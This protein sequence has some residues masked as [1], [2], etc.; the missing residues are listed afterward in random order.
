VIIK[1]IMSKDVEIVSPETLLHDVAKKM[2]VRDLGCIL[3]GKDDKLVGMITD[4]DIA[5]RCVALEH[6]P[7]E[8]TAEKIMSAEIL[9]CRETDEA[10]D[11]AKNMA[12]NKV[13]RLVVLDANKRMVGIVSLGDLAIAS[14]DHNICGTA[15]SIICHPQLTAVEMPKGEEVKT[16]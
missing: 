15:L 11:V 4:R 14:D 6:D 13:R 10:A 8:T 16:L 5:I 9:Y 12:Q 2:R 7:S 3:V 1:N